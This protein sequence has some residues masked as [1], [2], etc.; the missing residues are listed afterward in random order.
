MRCAQ[1]FSNSVAKGLETYKK[2]FPTLDHADTTILF[3]KRLN[4][5][6]DSLNRRHCA[7]GIRPNSKDFEV[8]IRYLFYK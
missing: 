5:L 4:N 8:N 2:Y 1:I 3:T 7:E 6:F